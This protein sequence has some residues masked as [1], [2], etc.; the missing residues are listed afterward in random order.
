MAATGTRAR[1]G[2]FAIAIAEKHRRGIDET[3]SSRISSLERLVNFLEIDSS[4]AV[5]TCYETRRIR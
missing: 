1:A 5:N 2:F 3:F 4:I